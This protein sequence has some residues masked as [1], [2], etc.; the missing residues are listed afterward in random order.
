MCGL[1]RCKYNPENARKALRRY[2]GTEEGKK[3]GQAV[4]IAL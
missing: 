4:V 3:A 1:R 2:G